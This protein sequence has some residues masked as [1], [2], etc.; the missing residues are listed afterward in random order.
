MTGWTITFSQQQDGW[1]KECKDCND[2]HGE[3]HSGKCKRKNLDSSSDNI[4]SG[5]NNWEMTNL[6]ARKEAETFF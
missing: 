5:L 6:S 2:K 1:A 4:G 3:E